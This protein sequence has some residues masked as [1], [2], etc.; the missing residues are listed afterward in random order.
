MKKYNN[1]LM[2]CGDWT[3][4]VPITGGIVE[5][6]QCAAKKIHTSFAASEKITVP[7]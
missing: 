5:I 4:S 1:K 2:G 3:S 6:H 7:K